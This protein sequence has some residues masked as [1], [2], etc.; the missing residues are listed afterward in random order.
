MDKTALLSCE[1]FLLDMDG[2]LYLGDEVFPG[3]VDFIRTLTKTGRRYIYLTNNSSRAGVDYVNRLKG[4]GFPCEMEN[5]FTS[6]MATG[7]YLKTRH[8]GER[9][10]AVGTPAFEAAG[11]Q[12]HAQGQPYEQ[13]QQ[14]A[15]KAHAG[16][17]GEYIAQFPVAAE[18]QL[19]GP[20]RCASHYFTSLWKIPGGSRAP[21]GE[22]LISFRCKIKPGRRWPQ[23][24]GR[25][26][27]R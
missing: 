20:F 15:G 14:G 18:Y 10:Y 3:A 25:W 19:Q 2:T 4:L 13:G 7:M 8:P 12:P 22:I 26:P 16:G 27:C 17:D 11:P 9:V 1:L 23:R 24:P 5:V 21:P 6:G